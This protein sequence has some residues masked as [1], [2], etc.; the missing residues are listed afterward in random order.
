MRGRA[1][2]C[3]GDHLGYVSE[4]GPGDFIYVRHQEMNARPDEP[5]EAVIVRSGQEAIA[6]NLDIPSLEHG[7]SEARKD[8]FH[9]GG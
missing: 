8:P 3:W 4:A 1:R 5:V 9:S 2:F 6:L 7:T